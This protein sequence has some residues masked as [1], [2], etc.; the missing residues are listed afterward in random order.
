M[1]QYY[2]NTHETHRL[3]TSGWPHGPRFS[4]MILQYVQQ[5]LAPASEAAKAGNSNLGR[6]GCDWSERN[7]LF[8]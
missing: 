1:I 4:A 2:R 8:S 7:M 5:R 6:A 3:M